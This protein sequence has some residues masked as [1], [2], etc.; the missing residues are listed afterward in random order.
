MLRTFA[1]LILAIVCVVVPLPVA[2]Q[3]GG[4]TTYVYDDNGR[5]HAV[6]SPAGEAAIY[7]YDAAGNVT[8]IRRPAADA[9]ELFSFSPHE[10]I[11]G[12]LVKFTGIGFRTGV[13]SV[14]F[15]GTTA[16]IVGGTPATV[17]AEVPLGATTGPVTINT[18]HGSLTT[19]IPFTIRGARVSPST[20]RLFFG[21]SV[22][23]TAEILPETSDQSVKW[24]VNGIEGGNNS[25]GTI[26]ATG[27][28]TAPNRV[29]TLVA[30]RATSIA[31]ELVIG[32]AQVSVRDPANVG[33]VFAPLV[34]VRRG[35]VISEPTPVLST[36][37]SV[38]HGVVIGGPA[39]IFS[40]LVSVRRGVV[41][42]GP[43]TISSPLISVRRGAAIGGATQIFSPL[44]SVR[45]GVIIS[46]PTLIF[47]PLI[48]V[49][50]GVVIGGSYSIFSPLV[51]VTTGPNISAISPSGVARGAIVTLSITGDNL[52]GASA[53]T[54]IDV[55]GMVDSSVFVSNLTVNS[56]GTLLT[57]MVTVGGNTM[58]GERVVVVT[59]SSGATPTI[60]VGLN[61]ISITQ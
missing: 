57:A 13:N 49:R 29:Q 11:P 35:V 27:L 55:N 40:P 3:Q 61:A 60:K 7:E 18:L 1:T 23:F 43:A 52:S 45:R 50:R 51:S 36:L 24:S 32:E 42:G 59:A 58:L 54:F 31:N 8:A 16:R 47:S 5:L 10:G 46:G 44:V 39:L 19:P 56:D 15:N 20:S 48:S 21:E 53:I 22:Q 4:I 28:Y 38:R 34:S 14:L 9:L 2:A 12:D 33:A 6:I 25:V 26:S 30:I 17:I 37:V 41:I